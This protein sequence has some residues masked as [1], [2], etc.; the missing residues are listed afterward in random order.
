M[1]FPGF[2]KLFSFSDPIASRPYRGEVDQHRLMLDLSRGEITTNEPIRVTWAMG[3]AIP[4]DIIWTTSATPIIVHARVLEVFQH[5]QFTGWSTYPVAVWTK[6]GEL[7][8]DYFGLAINGRCARVDLSRS[9]SEL[10]EYPGGWVPH[11]RG[12]FFVPDTWDGSDLFMEAPDQA[13]KISAKRMMTDTVRRA[14]AKAKVRNLE[15]CSL[16]DESVST[17]VYTIALQHLLP[18]DFEQRVAEAYAHA[19]VPR[20]SWK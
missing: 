16:P 2:S 11:F 1:A 14:L 5:H 4:S 12:H 10:R 8:P 3:S 7:A 9:T 18:P 20:P 17:S 13:G 6:A 15:L 19:G